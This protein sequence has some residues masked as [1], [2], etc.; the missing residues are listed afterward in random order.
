MKTSGLGVLLDW[1]GVVGIALL[2]I[3][4]LSGAAVLG[5]TLVPLILIGIGAGLSLVWLLTHRQ[6]LAQVAGLRSTQTNTNI[7]IS[8]VSVLVILVLLNGLTVRFDREFDL[9]EDQFFSFSSQTVQLVEGLDQPVKIWW[10]STNPAPTVR[11]SLERYE[12]LNP[13]QVDFELLN[14]RRSP[15]EAERL[16]ITRNDMLVVE[17]G[18]RQQ[19]IPLPPPQ[20]LE[21]QLT[22][23]ILKVTNTQSLTVYF[24]QGH[25]E[26]PLAGAEGEPTLSQATTA[27]EQ[28]GFTV[29]ELN[30]V[31]ADPIPADG[32]V[33]LAGPER[34]L[35]PGETDKLKAYVDQGGK[36]ALLFNPQTDPN[37]DD[38]LEDWGIELQDDVVVDLLSEALFRSGPFVALGASYGSHPITEA[39]SRQQLATL[40][41]LARSISTAS[42]PDTETSPLV[43]TSPQGSWGEIGVNL[44]QRQTRQPE[45][46][47]EEDIE[48][49]LQLA[50]AL[51]RAV[52]GSEPEETAE[53]SEVA[54]DQARL[55]VFGNAN[56]VV[57]G[58]FNQQGNGDL[59][60]NSVN[61]LADQGD[62]ISIR[63]KAPTNRRL[64]LT[65]ADIAALR[66][67]AL[68]GLPALALGTAIGIWWQRR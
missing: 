22:P 14:P 57:D 38:L 30:L 1:S 19:E 51:S 28:D 50:V 24:V 42:V 48:G 21:S 53:G 10:V 46:D 31:A 36:L 4:L 34:E 29:E 3:G 26:L 33:I 65:P 16:G 7:V 67:V 25:G 2:A 32:V 43:L 68:A 58:N 6:V 47:P 18:E 61:W 37:L 66:L 20:D 52:E 54:E 56:F 40:F 5:W 55:V 49:P 12:R 27:L 15:A 45:F 23:L 13:E 41:P 17:S 9:S 44:N 59:F 8:A 11:E 63:P 64:T 60:L 39:L 35:L 62:Q